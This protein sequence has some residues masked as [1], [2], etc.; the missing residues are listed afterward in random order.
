MSTTRIDTNSLPRTHIKGSGEVTEVINKSLC[1][2]DNVLGQLRWLA[3]GD[4]YAA[5]ATEATHQLL[6]LMDGEGTIRLDGKDYDVAKGAGIYLG[7]TETASISHRG[8]GQLKL[9]HLVVPIKDELQL[10]S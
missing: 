9:F 5:P 3:S 8:S 10:D 2:A 4:V 6:Y 1:G 7:P